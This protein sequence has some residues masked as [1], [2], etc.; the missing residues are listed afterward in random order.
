MLS[1]FRKYYLTPLICLSIAF[2]LEAF[3][4]ENVTP[5]HYAIIAGQVFA[6][7]LAAIIGSL[8]YLMDTRWGPA[9]RRKRF[10]RSPF[11]ELSELG[12]IERNNMLV[13]LAEDFQVLANYNWVGTNGKPSIELS[14]LFDPRQNNGFIPQ[15]DI[16]YWNRI[17]V[18]KGLIWNR[19]CISQEWSFNFKMPSF[20][21][22]YPFFDKSIKQLKQKRL[23]P[24]T[25]EE[26]DKL[27]EEFE[28]QL[29]K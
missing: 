25:L 15:E 22:I 6:M 8:Y 28:K 10:K 11:K 29:K 27:F 20:K 13:G 7:A 5:L 26:T 23:K 24:I 16:D 1:I 17:N 19:N 4:G 2:L 21:T 18:E 14:I 9:E 12:F 3:V